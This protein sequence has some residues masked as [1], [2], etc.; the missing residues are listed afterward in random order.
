MHCYA[1]YTIRGEKRTSC[2]EIRTRFNFRGYSNV[3]QDGIL[4]A[5]WQPA[6]STR[7][8]ASNPLQHPFRRMKEAVVGQRHALPVE[9]RLRPHHEIV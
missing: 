8:P 4:R 6:L 3:G 7:L 5:G 2:S 1:N 9:L